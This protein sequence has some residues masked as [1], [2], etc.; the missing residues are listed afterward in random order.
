VLPARVI[1]DAMRA[2]W[3]RALSCASQLPD[4]TRKNHG[5]YVAVA[6]GNANHG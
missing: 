3:L 5:E 6:A 1:R 2:F 4:R